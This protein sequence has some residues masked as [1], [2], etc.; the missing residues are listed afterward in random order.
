MHKHL[1]EDINCWI[2]SFTNN[3]EQIFYNTLYN[4]LINENDKC[5]ILS[6]IISIYSIYTWIICKKR[7][8][9]KAMFVL[10]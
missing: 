9:K 8:K 1:L 5:M 7:K 3:S 4:W 6:L 10:Y 2:I